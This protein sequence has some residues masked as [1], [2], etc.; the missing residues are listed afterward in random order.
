MVN[1]IN[2]RGGLEEHD[3]L[4]LL[5]QHGHGGGE[6]PR[7]RQGSS[8]A[9]KRASSNAAAIRSWG[10]ADSRDDRVLRRPPRCKRASCCRRRTSCR[11]SPGSARRRA[12]PKKSI[13]VSISSRRFAGHLQPLGFHRFDRWLLA[14]LDE[15]V[16][17][18]HVGISPASQGFGRNRRPSSS[19]TCCCRPD[20]AACACF[21][22]KLMEWICRAV[23]S[24][25]F[26]N[27]DM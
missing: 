5:R 13:A 8:S 24:D 17:V 4:R 3:P 10:N 9:A 27:F 2:P 23:S 19:R 1:C 14:V 12:L 15:F 11:T 7:L 16:E 22:T 6:G 18:F 21:Q 25:S 20:Q 26:I